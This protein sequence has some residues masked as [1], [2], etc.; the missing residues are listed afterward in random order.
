TWVDRS[1]AEPGGPDGAGMDRTR[2]ERRER[3]HVA[4]DVGRDLRGEQ[5][6][7]LCAALPGRRAVAVTDEPG[8]RG[9]LEEAFERGLRAIAAVPWR[10]ARQGVDDQLVACIV[11]SGVGRRHDRLI[12]EERPPAPALAADPEPRTA[13]ILEAPHPESEVHSGKRRFPPHRPA[14]GTGCRASE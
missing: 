13:V 9:D 10:G 2:D 6:R 4:A 3:G 1:G 12:E 14:A 5:S 7:G 8:A 11:A